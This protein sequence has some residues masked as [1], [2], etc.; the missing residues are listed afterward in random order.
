MATALSLVAVE[1]GDGEPPATA[2]NLRLEPDAQVVRLL[3]EGKAF[4]FSDGPSFDV[5][6]GALGT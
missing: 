3:L 5:V 4:R 1:V 2:P 6:R